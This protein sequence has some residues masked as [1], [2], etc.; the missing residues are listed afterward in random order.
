MNK[1]RVIVDF[2]VKEYLIYANSEIEAKLSA[3]KTARLDA[4]RNTLIVVD[5]DVTEWKDLLP[6]EKEFLLADN[7]K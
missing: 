7:E 6:M 4:E 5:T 2:E 1:Y 3:R